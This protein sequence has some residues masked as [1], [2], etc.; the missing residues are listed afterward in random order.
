MVYPY[1]RIELNN[2][3]AEKDNPALVIS[4]KGRS[5][6]VYLPTDIDK[7]VWI[8]G[9]VDMSKLIQQAV[10][11]MLKDNTVVEVKGEG[12]IEVFAWETEPGF[13]VLILNY[14]NP[15]MTRSSLRGYN[16]IGPQRVKIELP[17]GAKIKRAEMLRSSTALVFRQ[18]G[19]FVEFT[20]P[21]ITD[22]EIAALY[23][24]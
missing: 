12:Y 22:F 13:A 9:S 5:R 10:K 24:A 8:R 6:L 1:P 14:N 21:S 20:I 18:T 15:N 19:N 16:K 4:E 17:A 23:K 11:W 7:N 3:I 2:E